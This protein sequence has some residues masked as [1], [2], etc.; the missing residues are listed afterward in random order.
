MAIELGAL[1]LARDAAVLGVR[2]LQVE[3]LLDPFSGRHIPS[4][5]MREH[6][7]PPLTE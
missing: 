6:I 5:L 4:L 3:V 1:G 7:T 2:V